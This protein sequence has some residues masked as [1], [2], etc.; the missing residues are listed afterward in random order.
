MS[1]I[2]FLTLFRKND[3]EQWAKK[4]AE[5]DF[6]TEPANRKVAE[7]TISMAYKNAGIEPPKEFVWCASPEAARAWIR[8]KYHYGQEEESN[9][10][11]WGLE[12]FI[13]N[14]CLHSSIEARVMAQENKKIN[15]RFKREHREMIDTDLTTHLFE[16]IQD[17]HY[18]TIGLHYTS[19]YNLSNIIW[20]DFW[21]NVM[22]YEKETR[23]TAI[24]AQVYKS[25][26]YYWP[27]LD[28]CLVMDR[29]FL[30]HKDQENLFHH[31]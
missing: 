19:D 11:D 9:I 4:W 16:I 15:K 13:Q 26:G 2:D 22:G 8:E 20:M 17:T 30:I 10:S 31:S 14:E 23:K 12:G 27:F 7:M 28:F 3:K 29:P 1:K 25:C 24:L 21:R 6:S 18:D 5:L